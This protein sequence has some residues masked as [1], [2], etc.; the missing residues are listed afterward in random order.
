M[1]LIA[2]LVHPTR[3]SAVC[4]ALE[5]FGFPDYVVLPAAARG[6]VLEYY[7]GVR[8][9]NPLQPESCVQ[10]VAPDSE[11]AELVHVISQV[12]NG[13]TDTAGLIWVV[14]VS[15]FVRIGAS[16]VDEGVLW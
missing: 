9:V 8:Y 3:L 15:Q 11:V 10:L 1:Q 16:D 5:A 14:P 12:A 2:A 13:G 4:E 6:R 7:R